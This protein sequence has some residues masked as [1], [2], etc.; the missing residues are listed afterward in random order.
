MALLPVLEELRQELG[1]LRRHYPAFVTGGGD[2]AGTV[3]VFVFHSILPDSF[4][5]QLRYLRDNGYRT[6]G[7]DEFLSFLRNEWQPPERA[8]LLTIDDA[9]TSVWVYGFPLLRAYG[10]RATLF[11]IPGYVEDGGPPRPVL[12]GDGEPPGAV[13]AAVDDPG[14]ATWSEL[15]AMEESGLVDIQSHSLYH[16]RVYVTPELLGFVTPRRVEDRA[17]YDLVVPRGFE[18]RL[19]ERGPRALLGAPIFGHRSLFAG[20]PR[21]EVPDDAVTACVEHVARN[22]E[23]AFFRSRGWRRELER[24]VAG[25]T[26]GEPTFQTE[27]AWRREVAEDL[28]SARSLLRDRLGGTG[29]RHFCLPFSEGSVAVTEVAREVG[30]RTVFWGANVTRRENRAGDDP[31]RVP[32]LKEDFIHRLPG[33]GRRSLAAIYRGKALRRLS[34]AP[35]Y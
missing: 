8:V 4:E 33:E 30:Y 12:E 1:A 20:V 9:R 35:V 22:G 6:L 25:A 14:L 13:R 19:R 11:V 3:P 34:G 18:A 32:R 28:A 10:M 23:D 16:R 2:V 15:E 7:T 31:M 26:G 17:P 24:L 21:Y 27:E 5:A 29:V